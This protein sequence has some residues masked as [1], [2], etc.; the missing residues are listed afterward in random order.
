[1]ASILLLT[2]VT[3]IANDLGAMIASPA[4]HFDI[5]VQQHKRIY[6]SA[7][8]RGQRFENFR[9][10][11]ERMHAQADASPLA[12]FA[13]DTF[14]D[15]DVEEL[16][17]LRGGGMEVPASTIRMPF[18]ATEVNQALQAGDL[19]WVAKGVVIAP[20]TQGKCATCAYFAGISV[21]ESAWA[22]AGHPLVKLSE[23]EEID[24]YNNA[25]Y[26]LP[27]AEL[28]FELLSAGP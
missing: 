3:T 8:E 1:M 13:P 22:L 15:Y 6:A 20:T 23:Q 9:V 7:E 25:G 21:A 16:S 14:A 17:A 19:D 10:N 11:L 12:T 2:T 4:M 5:W 27:S 18:S 24:C 26:T 28:R